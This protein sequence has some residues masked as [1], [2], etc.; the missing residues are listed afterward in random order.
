MKTKRLAIGRKFLLVGLPLAVAGAALAACGSGE[1]TQEDY[2]T[3]TGEVCA[4]YQK[5][6]DQDRREVARLAER[7]GD[8][9]EQFVDVVRQFERDWDEFAAALKAVERPPADERELDRFFASLTRSQDRIADLATVVGEL[10]ALTKQVKEV[11]Q[12]QDPTAAEALIEDAER[13][14]KDIQQAEQGF[15]EAIGKVESFVRKYPG[16]AD[17]R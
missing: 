14:Q 2:R 3:A 11:Q 16:L 15:D 7:S 13:I 17:C 8:N 5:V 12:S 4:K 9:P 10:P 6:I 1:V